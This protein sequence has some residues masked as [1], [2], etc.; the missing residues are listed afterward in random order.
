M[1]DLLFITNQTIGSGGLERV[2]SIRTRALIDDFGY[3]IHII[4][5]NQKD[6]P[7]FFPF[8]PEINFHDIDYIGAGLKKIYHY[9]KEINKIIHK[10]KPD[11]ITVC[12]DGLKAFILPFMLT[13]SCPMI[14]ERHVSKLVE[15]NSD[16][17]MGIKKI[18]FC[19]K[20]KFMNFGAQH[21]VKVIVLTKENLKEWS[22]TDNMVIISNPIPFEPVTFS[23]LT[24]K[25]VIAVGRHHYQKGYDRLLQIWQSVAEDYPEWKLHIYGK[26]DPHLKLEAKAKEMNIVKS[27]TFFEP[28]VDIISKY[29][30]A[31]IFVLPSRFEG[32][33]M[34][35]IE[36]MAFGLPPISFNCPYGPSDIITHEKDGFLVED[37]DIKAFTTRL[38]SLISDQY[39]RERLGQEAKKVVTTYSLKTTMLKW[40]ELYQNLIE[41]V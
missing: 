28:V 3:R 26:K 1:S 27:V 30:E 12:D 31:S 18:I 9:K 17:L 11:L 10:I 21:Y 13:P 8:H 41:N 15:T 19:L 2:L 20:N 29:L 25:T 16:H 40:N 4:T 14:Y 24:N 34:V 23:T 38:K 33:G 36:A 39:L 32:F 7:S 35:L 22:N 37:G 5:L 6:L